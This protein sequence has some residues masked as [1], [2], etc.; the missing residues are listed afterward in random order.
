MHSEGSY[1]PW[2]SDTYNTVTINLKKK[3]TATQV[4][5]AKKTS[6]DF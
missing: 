2:P 5:V 1:W 3:V 4:T 6:L